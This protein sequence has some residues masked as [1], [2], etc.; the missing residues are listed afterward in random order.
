MTIAAQVLQKTQ[1][2]TS[3]DVVQNPHASRWGAPAPLYFMSAEKLL[4]E[5]SRLLKPVIF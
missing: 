4:A 3:S 5:A 2:A 1:R